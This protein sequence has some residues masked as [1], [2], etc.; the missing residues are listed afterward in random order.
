LPRS[1]LPPGHPPPPP[2]TA[3]VD[4]QPAYPRGRHSEDEHEEQYGHRRCDG[5]GGDPDKQQQP[6][7]DLR[8][9]QPPSDHGLHGGRKQLVRAHRCHRGLRIEELERSCDEEHTTK[10]E[11]CSSRNPV[12]GG[13]KPGFGADR[14]AQRDRS[15][16]SAKS[17][18]SAATG[19][20][21]VQITTPELRLNPITCAEWPTSYPPLGSFFLPSMSTPTSLAA[22]LIVDIGPVRPT[23]PGLNRSRKRRI[24]FSW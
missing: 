21:G 19:V 16:S 22:R 3:A 5:S 12:G 9:W 14:S 17:C 8:E 13:G 10:H 6:Q 11:T 24:C 7:G 2:E 1:G 18:L 20:P 4:A 23:K 15:T